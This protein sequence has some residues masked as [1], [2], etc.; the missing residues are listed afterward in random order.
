MYKCAICGKE[1]ETIA[2][3]SECETKCLKLKAGMEAAKKLAEK[4]SKKKAAKEKLNQLEEKLRA[5][6]EEY[7]KELDTYDKEFN[8]EEDCE[9][10]LNIDVP[11][12]CMM[13]GLFGL[14][15]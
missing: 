15:F 7:M 14:F 6:E 9:W 3:R 13:P 10:V 12:D 2:E 5:M 1:Y 4:K 8:S 11:E